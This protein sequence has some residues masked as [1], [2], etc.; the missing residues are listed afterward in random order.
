MLTFISDKEKYNVGETVKISI[1]SG[2]DGRALISIENGTDVIQT[3]WIQTNEGETPF[4]FKVT[5]DMAPNIYVHVSLLQMHSQ[6]ANDLPIRMYGAIPIPVED[7]DTR[8]Q[9]VINMANE[10]ES[11]KTFTINISEKNKKPMTY[12]LAVVDEGLLDLTRFSTPNPWDKF[13]AKE[14]LGV[15]TW[16]MYNE[17]I[18]A[19]AGK[20]E[21]LLAIGGDGEE[22]GQSKQT[23]NRFKP[24]VRF[25]GPFTLGRGE[26]KTH[27]VKISDYIGSVRTMVIA[28]SDIAY[29]SAEKAVPVLKPLMVFGTLPRV[30]SPGETIKLPVTI[31]A[32]KDN[33]KNVNVVIKTN[34]LLKIK[35]SASKSLKFDKPGE[36]NSGI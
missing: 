20:I 8:L 28:G 27:S 31:F 19:Y 33:I 13:Y 10:I 3:H 5:K 35:G 16:D 32:M 12:T 4:E 22:S 24:V 25:Y 6:T 11:G 26:N 23:A 30:L 17:V 34:D 18:G 9:P 36:E 2:K 1:P 15:K 21:R 7:P 29:G 14:A